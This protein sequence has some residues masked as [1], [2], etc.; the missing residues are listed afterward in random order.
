MPTAIELRSLSKTFAPRLLTLENLDLQ[1]A[2]GEFVSVMGPSGCGKSTLLRLI[3]GLET[4]SRGSIKIADAFQSFGFV[5]QEAHL[6]PWRN[7]EENIALPLQFQGATPEEI[8]SRITAMLE[9]IGLTDFR[10]AY[11]SQL[12][13]G[14]KMRASLAR[15]LITRPKILLLDEPFAALEESLRYRL[16]IELRSLWKQLDLTVV[17]VTHSVSEAVFVSNRLITLSQRPGHIVSDEPIDLPQDRSA[18]MKWTQSFL[19]RVAR[20]AHQLESAEAKS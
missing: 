13:G 14:M 4:P 9:L 7:L 3:A 17:F 20:I 15:A 11:P 16:D 10:H 12:S 6:L 19:H 2:A 1:I 18:E 8:Q 5:F